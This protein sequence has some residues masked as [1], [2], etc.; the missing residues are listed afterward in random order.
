MKKMWQEQF[1]AMKFVKFLSVESVMENTW[2]DKRHEYKV[3]LNLV[4]G[5][6]SKKPNTLS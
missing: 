3:V 4:M 1:E 5:E 2:T 6:S